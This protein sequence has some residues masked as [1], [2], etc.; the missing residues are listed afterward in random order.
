MC[1]L[2]V[3]G[4]LV[5]SAARRALQQMRQTEQ[6]RGGEE[7]LWTRRL[8][9]PNIARAPGSPRRRREPKN[10]VGTEQHPTHAC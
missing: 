5:S 4:T 1:T 9:P 8:A 7:A 10:W 2:K 3:R 6:G